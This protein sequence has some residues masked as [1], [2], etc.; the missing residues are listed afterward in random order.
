VQCRACGRSRDSS[1]GSCS[2]GIHRQCCF[3]HPNLFCIHAVFML[4]YVI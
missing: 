1:S 3:E 4:Y 2:P